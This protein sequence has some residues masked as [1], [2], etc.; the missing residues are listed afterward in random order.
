MLLAIFMILYISSVFIIIR[1]FL[2]QDSQLHNDREHFNEQGANPYIS[3]LHVTPNVGIKIIPSQNCSVIPRSLKESWGGM[4]QYGIFLG[5]AKEQSTTMKG[6]KL[7]EMSLQSAVSS[8]VHNN[9]EK[10]GKYELQLLSII[11]DSSTLL[12]VLGPQ[13]APSKLATILSNNGFI[14]STDSTTD[15]VLDILARITPY[16]DFAKHVRSGDN[17]QINK[18]LSGGYGPN[19]CVAIWHCHNNNNSDEANSISKYN[20]VRCISYHINGN[21]PEI[22]SI[23]SKNTLHFKEKD[24]VDLIPDVRIGE[25]EGKTMMRTMSVISSHNGIFCDVKQ[26]ENVSK[27]NIDEFNLLLWNC[28]DLL[29]EKVGTDVV[30]LNNHYN[31]RKGIAFCPVTTDLMVLANAALKRSVTVRETFDDK[32]K[33]NTTR[34]KP[35]LITPRTNVDLRRITSKV[36]TN[37]GLG[38]VNVLKILAILPNKQTTIHSL[39]NSPVFDGDIVK[40][41]YQKNVKDNGTYFVIKATNGSMLL[42]THWIV[43]MNHANKSIYMHSIDSVVNRYIPLH[44]NGGITIMRNEYDNIDIISLSP[45]YAKKIKWFKGA[46]LVIFLNGSIFSTKLLK[47]DA[48]TAHFRVEYINVIDKLRYDDL[49]DEN[50]RFH[51]K[52]T[53]T[54]DSNIPTRELC[55]LNDGAI[56]D[57]PCNADEECPFFNFVQNRGGCEVNTG[58]CEMPLGVYGKGYKGYDGEPITYTKVVGQSGKLP[59]FPSIRNIPSV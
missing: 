39:D 5:E 24:I 41:E 9:N 57:T 33:S 4:H 8:L 18:V 50:V 43:N 22:L 31:M 11:P 28:L 19:A 26:Y 7:C 42:S 34:Q 21:K 16:P 49:R 52:A 35:L 13:N 29:I 51:P 23:L 54:K 36:L 46:Q 56:W 45:T 47:M 58:K 44:H 55:E 2:Q 40:L 48:H 15:F 59:V 53:C 6:I 12:L 10:R 3:V 25:D 1:F 14:V 20:N 37:D 32:S 27:E 38:N 30:M 17:A